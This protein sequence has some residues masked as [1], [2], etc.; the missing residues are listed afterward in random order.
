MNELAAD[1]T[2]AVE[3][4]AS[5]FMEYLPNVAGAMLMLLVGWVAAYLT[6]KLTLRL[7]THGL[8]M[9]TKRKSLRARLQ[10]S[11]LL[12]GLPRTLSRV[13]FWLVL[14]FFATAAVDILGLTAVSKVLVDVAA[15]IPKI[16]GALLIVGVGFWLGETVRVLMARTATQT[17]IGHGDTLGRLSQVGTIA[18]ALIL[19]L[20]QLGVNSTVLVVVLVTL[21]VSTFGAGALAFGLGARNTVRNILGMHYSKG[22]YGTGDHIRVGN[23]QG[24]I[25]EITRTGVMLETPEG[26]VSVPGQL[27]SD[28][29]Y[30]LLSAGA[31]T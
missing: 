6:K 22:A 25:V 24:K 9:L 12:L 29:S 13:A 27:F 2:A 28:Q 31:D 15:Y 10:Q 18:V 16:L 23:I 5:R 14:L 4:A 26:Q 20:D 1:S 8:R 3:R 19:A 21:F 11:P 7:A 30:L 17:S